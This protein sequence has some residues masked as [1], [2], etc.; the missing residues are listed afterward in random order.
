[1]RKPKNFPNSEGCIES[2]VLQGISGAGVRRGG[3]CFCFASGLPDEDK[4]IYVRD[5]QCRE[6]CKGDPT[7]F[8]GGM[9]AVH[10]YVASIR[11]KSLEHI[12][13]YWPAM[14]KS[15]PALVTFDCKY[16]RKITGTYNHLPPL[17]ILGLSRPSAG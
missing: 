10:I 13:I 2:C 16:E 15:N 7:F 8:C 1:M 5:E 11:E 4:L 17:I 9:T 12:A 3:E 6:P 14:N